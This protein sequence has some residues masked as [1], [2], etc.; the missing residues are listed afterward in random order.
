[1]QGVV[2][3]TLASRTGVLRTLAFRNGREDRATERHGSEPVPMT[4]VTPMR[5]NGGNEA[6][7]GLL[8]R[9]DGG[10]KSRFDF[11]LRIVQYMVEEV[12]DQWYGPQDAFYKVRADDGN[13]Y[14]LRRETSRRPDG[15]WHLV[16][17]RQSAPGR[18]LSLGVDRLGQLEMKGSML[19]S[20]CRCGMSPVGLSNGC[21]DQFILEQSVHNR[22]DSTHDNPHCLAF[23]FEPFG[24]FAVA[25]NQS[26]RLHARQSRRSRSA[27]PA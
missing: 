1:M 4:G 7:S 14:I 5:Q 18:E 12:L 10:R 23:R 13:L 11:G 17:F 19:R 24:E 20:R 25:V 22:I 26:V 27:A 6:G 8:L 9:A 2:R 3:T 15:P 16:S 21:G